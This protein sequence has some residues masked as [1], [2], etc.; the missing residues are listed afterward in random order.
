MHTFRHTRISRAHPARH[1]P[2]P[3]AT[4]GVWQCRPT[5]PALL[6]CGPRLGSAHVGVF[7]PAADC[8][9]LPGRA[10]AG[11]GWLGLGLAGWLRLAGAGCGCG[12]LARWLAA[13][14]A[15]FW[16]LNNP[17]LG[18]AGAGR[19]GW[20]APPCAQARGPCRGCAAL[21]C[22]TWPGTAPR[23]AR[24]GACPLSG[25]CPHSLPPSALPADLLPPHVRAAGGDVHGH[26]AGTAVVLGV[27]LCMYRY[28]RALHEAS[29]TAGNTCQ[30][31]DLIGSHSEGFR[32]FPRVAECFRVLLSV[33]CTALAPLPAEPH[34]EAQRAVPLRH[35]HLLLRPAHP[36][37]LRLPLLRRLPGAGGPR[38]CATLRALCH[39]A[40]AVRQRAGASRGVRVHGAGA[41]P[42]RPS[43]PVPP[44][45]ISFPPT[46]F[47]TQC[48]AIGFTPLDFI[49]PLILFNKARPPPQRRHLST[50]S[51]SPQ[52]LPLRRLRRRRSRAAV[53][54]RGRAVPCTSRRQPCP[55]P[56]RHPTPVSAGARGHGRHG[57]PADP[58]GAHHPLHK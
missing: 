52:H 24:C 44:R 33:W 31:S 28:R 16:P 7:R 19:I 48:G 40:R 18:W 22:G 58:L 55:A 6:L 51:A 13:V 54:V 8:G 25:T 45:L 39:A 23:R 21:C 2:S 1:R 9:V 5:L 17:G 35:H 42:M 36:H 10:A 46:S 12:W 11:W 15:C 34:V 38:C 56:C 43:T 20:P 50:A 29:A 57:A 30:P 47:P 32:V 14:H 41:Q 27:V 3:P 4:A 37:R 49:M 53:A 26:Q